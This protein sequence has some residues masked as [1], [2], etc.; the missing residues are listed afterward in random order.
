[1]KPAITAFTHGALQRKVYIGFQ[2]GQVLQYNSKN[3]E[4]LKKVNDIELDSQIISKQEQLALCP[5]EMSCLSSPEISAMVFLPDE[6]ILI[7]GTV[8]GVIKLYDE[9]TNENSL[10][11]I[12]SGGHLSSEIT[13]L[14]YCKKT[15]LLVS[16]S[17]NGVVC[18]WNL[19]SNK[20][21]QVCYG[22]SSKVIGLATLFPYPLLVVC[23]QSGMIGV[24]RLSISDAFDNQKSKYL[25]TLLNY[26][27]TDRNKRLDI[28]EE[29]TSFLHLPYEGVTLI[30]Q[31]IPL[32]KDIN[33]NHFES[34]DSPKTA[35]QN[36][37]PGAYKSFKQF[38]QEERFKVENRFHSEMFDKAIKGL[39]IAI[40]NK[41]QQHYCLIGTSRGNLITFDLSPFILL[42]NIEKISEEHL[43]EF[44]RKDRMR[45]QENLCV[46]KQVER[47]C[48]SSRMK[49]SVLHDVYDL[50]SSLILHKIP[51]AR[52]T[53]YAETGNSTV[54]DMGQDLA[55]VNTVHEMIVSLQYLT[56]T[57]PP[58]ILA[59]TPT[60]VIVQPF[61]LL[62]TSPPASKAN[63]RDPE[64][65]AK[66]WH[67]SFDW[68]LAITQDFERVYRVAVEL[69]GKDKVNRDEIV[70]WGLQRA[71]D[72]T[73]REQALKA[74]APKII[75]QAPTSNKFNLSNQKDKPREKV[76]KPQAGLARKI[77]EKFAPLQFLASSTALPEVSSLDLG[78]TRGQVDQGSEIN[79]TS[80]KDFQQKE[81]NPIAEVAVNKIGSQ[82][83]VQGKEK[84]RRESKL[85]EKG[86]LFVFKEIANAKKNDDK[87]EKI[88]PIVEP[89]KEKHLSNPRMKDTPLTNLHPNTSIMV[90]P[91]DQ[92]PNKLEKVK[93]GIL[94]LK[95]LRSLSDTRKFPSKESF[96]GKLNDEL[97][98]IEQEIE[99]EMKRQLEES[100]AQRS[101]KGNSPSKSKLKAAASAIVFTS[102]M[103]IGLKR[104][105][106][107]STQIHKSSSG[108][109]IR[110]EIPEAANQP[111]LKV[112][113]SPSR[114]SR[115]QLLIKHKRGAH[116]LHIQESASSSL[117]NTIYP[118][119][120]VEGTINFIRKLGESY[121]GVDSNSLLKTSR[122]PR[123]V[124]RKIKALPRPL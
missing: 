81:Q 62:S 113:Q 31:N 120:G 54:Q 65:S 97:F 58:S 7:V 76:S 112:P 29:I 77:G 38:Y 100:L 55:T 123:A 71:I 34:E 6:E 73:S 93:L 116:S 18:V 88:L 63:I 80:F 96:A 43:A 36:I 9:G 124:V 66:V 22:S 23:Y 10:I 79:I 42:A 68:Q 94:K 57:S 44:T 85:Q 59:A 110:I 78:Q 98:K 102:K 101:P 41:S 60:R 17:I 51:L 106:S 35:P 119:R 90:K 95:S 108:S 64:N 32:M 39:Q 82:K 1:M 50:N 83:N 111:N 8:G 74:L 3:I 24:W 33:R 30:K 104:N 46:W 19:G 14:H 89:K 69:E 45:S 48:E 12:F 49:T 11:K 52:D 4:F 21:E 13:C 27:I 28:I 122:T 53:K 2:D 20:L 115:G 72:R 16:G 109:S 117:L 114:D 67:A 84:S 47:A 25:L 15:R 5:A 107:P 103:A 87:Q 86:Q 75:K 70:A 105:L 26:Q 118:R 61:P 56:Q 121:S 99:Q 91:A 37:S 92:K 40:H